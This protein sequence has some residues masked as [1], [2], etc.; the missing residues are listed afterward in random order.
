M[1]ED[2]LGWL[3]CPVC[4]GSLTRAD[5][6][7]GCATGH[8]FDIARQGYVSLLPPGAAGSRGDPA[9][10][11][12]ARKDFLAAGH[13]APIATALAAAA[14][15]G[16]ATPAETNVTPAETSATTA[17]TSAT[18][19]ETGAAGPGGLACVAD[20]GAG[21]GY[22]LAAVLDRLPGHAGL[23]MD[24]SRYALRAATLAHP[25]IGAVGADAW[26]RLPV[27]DGAA[28]LVLDVFAPRDGAELR[29]ILRPEGRLLV[30][31]PR[32]EHLAELIGPLGLLRVDD[33]KAERLA[34]TLGP[35]FEVTGEHEVRAPMA[36]D[37]RSAAALAAMGPSAW[38]TVAAETRAR[39]SGLPDPVLVTLAVTVSVLRPRPRLR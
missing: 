36:L 39:I 10:M 38:H 23:A 9:P 4:H 7:V 27:A 34:G 37:H 24:L 14:A 19:A 18:A 15:E 25:R 35:Y 29:R 11:V 32:P 30:V 16:G 2:V 5:R 20:V 1:L 21:T 22:Y 12:A 33:R 28:A 8:S 26:R 3:R 31:T 17:G 6:T 13:F